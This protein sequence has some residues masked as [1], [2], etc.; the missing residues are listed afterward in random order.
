[1]FIAITY[2]LGVL[3]IVAGA[4]RVYLSVN[5]YWGCY[6]LF[7]EWEFFSLQTSSFVVT[8]LLDWISLS[9]IGLVILI[10]SV[11]IFYRTYY[12]IGDKFFVRFIFLVYMFVASIVFIILSPNIIRILLG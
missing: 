11:V 12:I 6:T 4:V 2:Y 8:F 7:L 10:S 9:F 3:L 5:F 1:V